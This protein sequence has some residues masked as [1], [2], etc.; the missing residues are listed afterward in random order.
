MGSETII[1]V[2]KFALI[3]IAVIGIVGWAV[4]SDYMSY[5]D[6]KS[7]EIDK[8]NPPDKTYI[9]KTGGAWIEE[10]EEDKQQRINEYNERVKKMCVTIQ[11]NKSYKAKGDQKYYAVIK[12]NNNKVT[13]TS[14]MYKTHQGAMKNANRMKEFIE[15]PHHHATI[16]DT[17]KKAEQ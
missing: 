1:Y 16:K 6:Q 9:E 13:W 7:P 4:Y 12:A 14:E 10:P 15:N 3:S 11:I 5:F 8:D 17:T 2:L